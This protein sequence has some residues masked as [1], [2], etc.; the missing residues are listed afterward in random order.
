MAPNDF[1][2]SKSL[3]RTAK[4]QSWS[5]TTNL[6]FEQVIHAC[7]QPRSYANET[8]IHAEMIAAYCNL[9]QLSAASSVEVWA[10]V[11]QESELI[12]GLYGV[13]LGAI[14]CGESMFHKQTDAS[15]IAFWALM[16]LA[17]R[18]GIALI[19]CQMQN[20]HLIRLGATAM[21]K[22]EFL[23]LLTHLVALPSSGLSG[24]HH[25]LST[26]ELLID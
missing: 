16:Q 14:F 12:G 26:H 23:T 11:P 6:A 21:P 19:D 17:K 18:T 10:G 24:A 1:Q 15:K 3:I 2:P 8:W 9:H 25:R 20:P 13:G 5:I 4:K 7:S 22:V